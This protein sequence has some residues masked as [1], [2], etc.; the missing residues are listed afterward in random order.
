MSIPLAENSVLQ[1]G[2]GAQNTEEKSSQCFT[3]P[4]PMVL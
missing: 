4:E 3:E 1:A 2:N